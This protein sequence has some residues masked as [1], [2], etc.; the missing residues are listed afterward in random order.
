MLKYV[1]HS[2]KGLNDIFKMLNNLKLLIYIY[3]LIWYGN[4]MEVGN[5]ADSDGKERLLSN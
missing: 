5:L 4:R 3:I 2:Y 1:I